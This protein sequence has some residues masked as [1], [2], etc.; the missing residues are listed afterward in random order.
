MIRK[1]IGVPGRHRSRHLGDHLA[2]GDHVLA[3][4]VPAL[5]G[6]D[7]ILEV[8]RG[9][10]GGL[11]PA[12]RPDH[13]DRVAIPGVGVGD[14]RQVDRLGDLAGV[15]DRLRHRQQPHI[16]AAKAQRG[17]AEAGHVGRGETRFLRQARPERVVAPGSEHHLARG[18]QIAQPGAP[19]RCTEQIRHLGRA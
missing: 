9:D 8:D 14:Q 2:G 4:R 1:I 19:T 15:V 18:E 16:G 7:L 11:V 3:L 13:V 6:H 10:S 17:G 5:L 12:N